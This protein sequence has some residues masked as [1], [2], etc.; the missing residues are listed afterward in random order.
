MPLPNLF[1]ADLPPEATISPQLVREACVAVKRNRAHWL[2]HRRTSELVE[3]LAYNAERWLDPGFGLR[4]SA[5]ELAP[6]E[7]GFGPATLAQG[8]DTFFRSLTVEQLNALLTQDLGDARRLDEFAAPPSELR[9]GRLAL[10]RGPDLLVHLAAGNLPN[11][12][13]LSLTLG[14]LTKSAQFMKLSRHG[15]VLPRLFAHSLADVEPKLGACLDLAVWPGGQEVL[16]ETLFAEAD[17]V[18]VQGTDET[19]SSVRARLPLGCRLVAYGHRLSFAFVGSDQLSS[20]LARKTASRAAADVVAWN[21]LGC[22]SPHVIYV[23]ERGSVSPEGFAEQLALALAER[24]LTEPRGELP[25]ETSAEL[26]SRRSLHELR[27]AR[28]AATREEAH[29]MPRGVFFEPPPGA[30]RVWSSTDSTAWTVV[31][32]DDARFQTSCLNRFIYVKPCRDLADALHQAEPV[33]G[34]VSTLGVALSESR[35]AELAPL[36]ARWGVSRI[37]P[38]GRMQEPPASWRHDGRPALAELV[39]W[40]DWETV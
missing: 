9:Q 28:Q 7:T 1:L 27:G 24:E 32:E 19:V 22:L 38:L 11:P 2:A 14:V 21:Q 16:E 33:R 39:S 20:F 31:F 26:A 6:A 29:T 3:L 25:V 35:L 15:T 40:T 13:L 36:I 10:A 37:C 34:R 18:T 8:L 5:L 23:E 17:C 30:T 4:R 12:A